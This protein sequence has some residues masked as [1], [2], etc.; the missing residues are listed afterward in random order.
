MTDTNAPQGYQG[1]YGPNSDAYAHVE[2]CKA[3]VALKSAQSLY[4]CGY[5]SI[6]YAKTLSDDDDF[7]LAMNA[8][9]RLDERLCRY[10]NKTPNKELFSTFEPH[11]NNPEL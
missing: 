9:A 3:A 2:I 7:R 8:L 5:M 4:C 6:E 11:Q 10:A 1:S